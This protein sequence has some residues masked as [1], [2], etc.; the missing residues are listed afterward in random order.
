MPHVKDNLSC[1]NARY[2][3]TAFAFNKL[4]FHLAACS[5]DGIGYDIVLVDESNEPSQAYTLS[6]NVPI[7]DTSTLKLLNAPPEIVRF[8]L[9]SFLAKYQHAFQGR[10]TKFLNG[11]SAFVGK[12]TTDP[13]TYDVLTLID[14][15]YF[16][17]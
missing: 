9:E 5:F 11:Y 7:C 15:T 12:I 6:S 8:I 1:E 4:K 16:C 17:E 2:V 10:I 3:Y 14:Q 13:L